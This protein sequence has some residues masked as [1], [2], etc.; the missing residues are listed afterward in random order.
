MTTRQLSRVLIAALLLG[1]SDRVYA[2]DCIRFAGACDHTPCGPADCRQWDTLWSSPNGYSA[3]PDECQTLTGPTNFFGFSQWAGSE[4]PVGQTFRPEQHY[5]SRIDV[6]FH[7]ARDLAP[8]TVKLWKW[9]DLDQDCVEDNS[10][11]PP[12]PATDEYEQTVNQQPLWSDTITLPGP[13]D[14]VMVPLFP[15]VSGLQ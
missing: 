13:D 12:N 11:N 14:W 15:N 2:V 8:I 6:V 1:L 4:Q 7:N 5:L 10:P 3:V 9:N